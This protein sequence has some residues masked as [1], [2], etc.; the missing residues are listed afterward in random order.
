MQFKALAYS[1]FLRDF[2][3]SSKSLIFNFLF[4]NSSHVQMNMPNL[5]AS[6]SIVSPMVSKTDLAGI[7][8]TPKNKKK[9]EGRD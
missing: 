7:I 3:Y 4:S 6:E 5:G 1:T 9:L 2:E 8:I